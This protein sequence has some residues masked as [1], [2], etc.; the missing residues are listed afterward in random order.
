VLLDDERFV[1]DP[2]LALP[3]DRFAAYEASLPA[4]ARGVEGHMLNRDGD[5]HRRLPPPRVEGVY[6]ADDR[7]SCGCGSMEIAGRP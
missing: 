3:P 6:A 1:R 4:G 7:A 2:R 5:D